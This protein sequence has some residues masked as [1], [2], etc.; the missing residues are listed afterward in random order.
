MSVYTEK[1]RKAVAVALALQ[2]GGKRRR[3]AMLSVLCTKVCLCVKLYKEL[4]VCTAVHRLR[5]ASIQC[6]T[7]RKYTYRNC[8]SQ[9]EKLD[10]INLNTSWT[11]P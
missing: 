5:Y 10:S 8:G 4:E 2:L 6:T 7:Q 3:Y 1:E 11:S 9:G